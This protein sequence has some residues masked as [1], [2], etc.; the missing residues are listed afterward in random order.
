MSLSGGNSG[1]YG[2]KATINTIDLVAAVEPLLWYSVAVKAKVA[3]VV[4]VVSFSMVV[5]EAETV[6][7]W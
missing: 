7:W 6:F 5:V 3:V 4:M 2:C 1:G